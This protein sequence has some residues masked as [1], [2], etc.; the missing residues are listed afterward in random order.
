M[1]VEGSPFHPYNPWRR[2]GWL[3]AA[4]SIFL[5]LLLG[6]VVLSPY[7]QNGP[8]LDTW[9]AICQS[10]GITAN[11]KPSEEPQPP[12]RVPSLI[13]WT[14]STL[15]EIGSGNAEHGAFIALNCTACHGEKGVSHSDLIP[16]LA[17]MDAESTYKQLRDFRSGK[18]LW[19]VMHGMATALTPQDL[20]DAAVYFAGLSK[21]SG[22][23]GYQQ[24]PLREEE[25]LVAG[26]LKKGDLA[27]RLVYIGDPQR[28][29]APCAACHGPIGRKIGAPPL[30]DQ[31]AAYIE[32][33]LAS[34][35]QGIRENDI[36]EQMR[37]IAKQLTPGEIQALSAFYGRH[38]A[39][40]T[41]EK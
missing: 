4:I 19:G 2:I 13:A 37:V 27:A 11:I 12:L 15:D 38:E 33:Q 32:R 10:L 17:G 28:T 18:R 31:Q 34:F 14:Q 5:A 7:Q 39:A 21:E 25:P 24:L 30:K 36:S 26:G 22:A 29:I 41:A 16:T 20:A 9:A 3:T 23:T 1:A 40:R 35:A 6:L 8:R